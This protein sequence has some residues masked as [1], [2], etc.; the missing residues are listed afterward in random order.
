AF[1]PVLQKINEIANSERFK[2]FAASA[3]Q[4]LYL[5]AG[6][7]DIVMNAIATVGSFIYDNWSFL[8]P[9]ILGIASAIG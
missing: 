5:T 8:G 6:V 3:T 1:G 9:I 4:A 7:I 2:A